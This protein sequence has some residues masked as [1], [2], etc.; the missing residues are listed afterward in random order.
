MANYGESLALPT[1]RK[2]WGTNVLVPFANY[3]GRHMLVSFI[4]F[5]D[6]WDRLRA[7][8]RMYEDDDAAFGYASLLGSVSVA[9]VIFRYGGTLDRTAVYDKIDGDAELAALGDNADFLVLVDPDWNAAAPNESCAKANSGDFLG[10]L[11]AGTEHFHWSYIVG[12]SGQTVGNANPVFDKYQYRTSGAGAPTSFDMIALEDGGRLVTSVDE[13]TEAVTLEDP[14]ATPLAFSS[15]LA[16]NSRLFEIRRLKNLVA[17]PRVLCGDPAEGALVNELADISS[18]KL[19]FSKPMNHIEAS[20]NALYSVS[21]GGSGDPPLEISGNPQYEQLGNAR[22]R[23]QITIDGT[24]TDTNADADILVSAGN[25][26][27]TYGVAPATTPMEKRI[28]YVVDVTPPRVLGVGSD[29][30]EAAYTTGEIIDLRVRFSEVVT[31]TGSPRLELELGAATAVYAGY[32]SGSG[33]DTLIFRYEVG[34]GHNSAD[35]D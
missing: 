17:V 22:N 34:A 20:T 25:I 14:P 9:S 19:Y 35:L 7:L 5:D 8:K 21:G 16:M 32:V 24:I 12:K 28:K 23:V 33:G 26:H 31:V 30:D 10:T 18:A 4:E 1:L 13:A 2:G 11:A 3:S 15:D 27:D 6:G 29:K